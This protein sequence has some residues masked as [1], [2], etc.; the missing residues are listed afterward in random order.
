MPNYLHNLFT[1][2]SRFEWVQ[3]LDHEEGKKPGHAHKGR[4]GIN[5]DVHING[6][7][8]WIQGPVKGPVPINNFKGRL[9]RINGIGPCIMIFQGSCPMH[10][11]QKKAW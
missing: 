9:Y 3:A 10:G 5:P 8:V 1:Q 11:K 2:L 7:Y 6:P 4:T